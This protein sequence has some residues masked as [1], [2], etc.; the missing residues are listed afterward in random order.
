MVEVRAAT[1]RQAE[2]RAV[3]LGRRV[4]VVRAVPTRLAVRRRAGDLGGSGLGG[5]EAGGELGGSGLGGAEAGG[6]LGGCDADL[7]NIRA[8]SSS[9]LR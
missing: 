7:A 4:V 9:C 8:R 2:R 3:T 1:S 5:S 6:V